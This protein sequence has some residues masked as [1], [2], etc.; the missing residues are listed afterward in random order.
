MDSYSLWIPGRPKAKGRPRM[1]R[2]GKAYTP[3][4][5]HLEEARVATAYV[6]DRGPWFDT[7][8]YLEVDYHPEGQLITLS[9]VDW[10]SPLTAD[11]DNLLKLT[12]DALQGVAFAN[13][14]AVVAVHGV[15]H[16]RGMLPPEAQ[17]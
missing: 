15:K 5:T 14:R 17:G 6:G 3:Q 10:E 11:T 8:V 2:R 4:T 1:T 9:E 16:P 12:A 13:D 7:S